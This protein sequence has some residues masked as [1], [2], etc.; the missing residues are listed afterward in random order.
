[1]ETLDRLKIYAMVGVI[2]FLL[3]CYIPPRSEVTPGMLILYTV[4]WIIFGY[5]MRDM[6]TIRR[7]KADCQSNSAR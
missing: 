7:D 6:Q 3:A 5:G 1:M 2:M 4:L